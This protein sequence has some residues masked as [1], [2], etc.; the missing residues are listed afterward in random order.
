MMGVEIV[1]CMCGDVGFSDKIFRC[2]NCRHRF[3]H[4]YCSNYYIETSELVDPLCDWCQ[5]DKIQASKPRVLS[6]KPA[7]KL[8]TGISNRSEHIGDKIKQHDREEGHSEKG[9][10]PTGVPSPRTAT[11]RYKLLKDVMS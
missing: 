6:K 8:D 5:I 10:S 2:N 9:K 3:E 4:W 1:C 7:S 11:R